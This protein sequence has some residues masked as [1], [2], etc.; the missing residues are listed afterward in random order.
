MPVTA[1]LR[2][3][4]VAL[5]REIHSDPEL[6][7]HEH[8]AV[9]RIAALLERHGHQ[10]ERSVGGL[11]TA[12]R[13]RVG[14]PGASVALLAEYDALPDVGHG[15]GHNL[16]AM[17]NV[18]AFLIAAEAADRLQVGV[19]IIGTPAEEDGGGKLDLLDA[20]IFAPAIAVLSSHPGGN[21][22]EAGST[23]LGI[24]SKRIG[25][26]GLASHAAESPEKGRN[27]LNAVIRLFLGVDGWRQHLPSDARVHGIITVGGAA[28]NIVP[29]YAEAVFGMRSRDP[30]TLDEMVRTFTD[31]AEG[32]ALQTGTTVEIT[33]QMR[34]YQ[35]TNADPVLTAVL[36]E[37][38]EE[39]GIAAG[40]HELVHA[41]TDLGNVS[42]AV[43][44]S[45]IGFP[46]ASEPIP[47]H[48]H[49]MRDASA[50]DVGHENGLVCAEVLAAVAVHVATDAALRAS[51]GR[52]S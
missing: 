5:S 12:F 22:W 8:R 25:F 13:A 49:L 20:G 36:A 24:V 28:H 26:H 37:E 31:I 33:D 35:P 50:S 9:G 3:E 42:Q 52:R 4:L 10:V 51:L 14:P 27:A 18:G 1:A 46:I 21:A 23:T 40:R 17:S 43:P 7:H 47:G 45:A 11:A 19:E 38:L 6:A 39:R 16:I 30:G 48:S 44:T 32:A 41:S 2:E 15:C 34:L 29:S